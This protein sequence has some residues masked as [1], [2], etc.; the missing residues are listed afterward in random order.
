MG[1]QFSKF[2][3]TNKIFARD[4]H[5]CQTPISMLSTSSSN[6]PSLV[7]G[8]TTDITGKKA[9]KDAS[10]KS[11]G[12]AQIYSKVRGTLLKLF[13]AALCAGCKDSLVKA[14][15]AKAAGLLHEG[16][17]LCRGCKQVLSAIKLPLS[18][19]KATET[20]ASLIQTRVIAEL[21]L[22]VGGPRQP[23]AASSK[24]GCS[25]SKE[26]P[27]PVA[28]PLNSDQPIYREL[29]KAGADWCRFCGTTAGVSWRPGPWGPR[30]L[31]FR[32][33]RDWAVHK[34][35]DLSSFE[36]DQADRENPVLQDYCKYCWSNSGIVRKCHGCANGFHAQCYLKRTN[37]SVSS[38]M[39][40]PWYCNCTCPKHFENGTI[41]IDECLLA[42][43]NAY[44]IGVSYGS[45]EKLP[46]YSH[47][48]EVTE[49]PEHLLSD[50]EENS[51]GEHLDVVTHDPDF[52]PTFVIRLKEPVR[53]ATPIPAIATVLKEKRRFSCPASMPKA[54]KTR[55]PRDPSRHSVPDFLISIDHS[56]VIRREEAPKP[57]LIPEFC[58]VKR[59]M[60]S[61]CKAGKEIVTEETFMSRHVRLEELEKHTRLL[62][63]D[64]LKTLFQK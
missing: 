64:I 59:P 17:G 50:S 22:L 7:R 44:F 48:C 2:L 36:N 13:V 20:A 1:A 21:D 29:T 47:D 51:C 11:T 24:N 63:P 61:S 43:S 26:A 27:S 3:P 41:S 38:L 35:L 40:K 56:V 32:H 49:T 10:S 6:V 9:S 5:P 57:V 15:T 12:L 58:V 8:R 52:K 25:D 42:M 31:C 46:F 18:G 23:G 33:G 53:P 39:A 19:D 55:R 16:K 30:S 4:H 54:K 62:K 28:Y 34:K 14:T 37:K 60:V 45:K